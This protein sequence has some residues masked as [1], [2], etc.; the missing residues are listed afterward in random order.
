MLGDVTSEKPLSSDALTLSASWA[1]LRSPLRRLLP[2][3]QLHRGLAEGLG[4]LATSASNWASGSTAPFP[5][6]NPV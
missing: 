3:P 2:H 4:E 1:H 5:A 6:A